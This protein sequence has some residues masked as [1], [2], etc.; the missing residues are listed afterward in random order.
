MIIYKTTNLINGKIYIGKDKH[1]NE[2]YLGS[3]KILKQ[4]IQKYGK[5][6]FKKEIIE[7]CKDE[8]LWLEREIYWIEY[9]N[10][11]KI[12]YNIAL[13]GH[14][15][16]TISNNPNKDDIRK[17][18]SEKMKDPNVNKN[19]ARGRKPIIKKRDDPNW[20]NPQKGKKCSS[21]GRPSNKKG[22]PNQKHSEWM[23]ENN[24]FRGKTHSEEH[25][26]KLK[27]INSK[28]KSEEHKRKIS[29]TLK[30]NKPG[31]MRKVEIESVIYESLTEASRQLQ[32]S[33]STVKN[34]LK[35]TSKKFEN[36]NYKMY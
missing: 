18:H 13:G 28:P 21:R 26:Q 24:P 11:T 3:G 20:I 6:N 34:R 32:L 10:S 25:K 14:G 12:G 23:K 4:A 9:F 15:G 31:N 22:I 27:E 35:S 36:W 30:G 1:N 7:E 2:N 16:D 33:I 19:K 17:R 29:E 8:K 5:E